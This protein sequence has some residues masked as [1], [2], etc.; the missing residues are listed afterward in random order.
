M[1]R[2]QFCQNEEKQTAPV[3]TS[4]LARPSQGSPP[5]PAVLAHPASGEP[6]PTGTGGWSFPLPYPTSLW[7]LGLYQVARLRSYPG[8]IQGYRG[9]LWELMGAGAPPTSKR[10]WQGTEGLRLESAGF[11]F[12]KQQPAHTCNIR[13]PCTHHMYTTHHTYTPPTQ[14]HRHTHT[15]TE[16]FALAS[17][18]ISAID[19][20]LT[21]GR[22]RASLPAHLEAQR[23]Q[24]PLSTISPKRGQP[25]G[26]PVVPNLMFA[27]TPFQE[28]PPRSLLVLATPG[29]SLSWL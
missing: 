3:T 10:A 12:Y 25:H 29:V 4:R 15:H 19:L 24:G 2:G 18:G 23:T 28:H 11:K 9:G 27:S 26:F 5:A 21:R 1:R 8:T 17:D 22:Q 14:I 7:P 16:T 6:I 13:H 20:G